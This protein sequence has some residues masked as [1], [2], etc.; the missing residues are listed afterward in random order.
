MGQAREDIWQKDSIIKLQN[1]VKTLQREKQDKPEIQV[2]IPRPVNNKDKVG[3]N[4]SVKQP[5]DKWREAEIVEIFKSTDDKEK[6][7]G[8]PVQY[9][10]DKSTAKVPVDKTAVRDE[11][12]AN[13]S[14][15]LLHTVTDMGSD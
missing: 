11:E 15:D 14:K 2:Q 6:V 13:E 7:D 10:D 5:D 1:Q 9:Y 3:D 4:I 8:V 12:A